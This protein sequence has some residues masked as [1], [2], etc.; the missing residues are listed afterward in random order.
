M[1][2]LTL[3]N[4]GLGFPVVG[5]LSAEDAERQQ[6]YALEKLEKDAKLQ[7]MCYKGFQSCILGY[8]TAEPK[9]L[10]QAILPLLAPSASFAVFH[11][12][13]Q[14]LAECMNEL[15]VSSASS[16]YVQTT[17]SETS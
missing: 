17:L 3:D 9:A 8:P 6:R 14:P 4:S 15:M 11:P 2:V 7:E 1:N 16:V 5:G 10:F 12:V 13:L